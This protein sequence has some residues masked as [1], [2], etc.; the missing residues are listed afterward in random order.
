MKR[1]GPLGRVMETHRSGVD[2]EGR[3]CVV[4]I[5]GKEMLR[6]ITKMAVLVRGGRG[7]ANP[8]G[9]AEEQ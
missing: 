6:P 9:E 4:K 2:G 1:V 8:E 3:S 5:R 7:E